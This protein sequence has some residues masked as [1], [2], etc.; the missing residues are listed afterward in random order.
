MEEL[1]KISYEKYAVYE[2][3][4]AHG[5]EINNIVLASFNT[6]KEADDAR[7]KYGYGGDNY[8]IDKIK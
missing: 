3:T 6:E 7:K 5:S 2:K 8:Y 4:P 1:I